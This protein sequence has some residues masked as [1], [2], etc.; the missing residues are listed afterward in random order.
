MRIAWSPAAGA[1]AAPRVDDPRRGPRPCPARGTQ[2]RSGRGTIFERADSG[3]RSQPSQNDGEVTQDHA[4]I[5]VYPRL[6]AGRSDSELLERLS[7]RLR[8]RDCWF[9]VVGSD[10]WPT[11]GRFLF[12]QDWLNH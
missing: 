4:D 11:G 1:A 2:F 8:S 3:N 5:T 12:G 10:D 7:P 6:T 9:A